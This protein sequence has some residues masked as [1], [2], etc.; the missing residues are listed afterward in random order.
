MPLN[1]KRKAALGSIARYA[2][3]VQEKAGE[4]SLVAVVVLLQYLTVRSSSRTLVEVDAPSHAR[5]AVNLLP[6]T[7]ESAL[8][9]ELRRMV[10]GKA[11]LS[12]SKK[13]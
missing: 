8:V 9:T 12:E 13:A 11:S 2:H 1:G 5:E 6:M 10:A 4:S 3:E 7:T